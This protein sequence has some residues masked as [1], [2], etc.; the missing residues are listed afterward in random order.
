MIDSLIN[1]IYTITGFL[2]EVPIPI[3][4][5]GMGLIMTISFK[6]KFILSVK[7]MWKNTLGLL[8]KKT[9]NDQKGGG[10]IS[11]WASG[12]T[13]LASTIGTGNIAGV[14]TAITMGGPGA[15]VW[16]WLSGLL[17]MSTKASEIILGQRYRI[18]YKSHDEYECDRPFVMRD[19]M[20]WKFGA[21]L[22]ATFCVLS[23][24]WSNLTQSEALASSFHAAFGVP[25]WVVLAIT[26]ITLL[27][28]MLGGLRRIS[29]VAE[30]IVPC[31]A[32][33]NTV[34]RS[35]HA[36]LRNEDWRW[37]CSYSRIFE[38]GHSGWLGY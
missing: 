37:Y 29:Q 9:A 34:P 35:Q 10:T 16:M 23:G 27:I 7:F 36:T 31:D 28:A 8:F 20:G 22:V 15:V 12:M 24:P 13:A 18:R 11:S 30:K 3:L 33:K 38:G 4:L 32:S 6:G 5:L 2:W 14:A 26:G 25:K 19:A 21:L 1:G 17:G